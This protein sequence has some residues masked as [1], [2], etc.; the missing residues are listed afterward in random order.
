MFIIYIKMSNPTQA[1]NDK[2]AWGKYGEFKV[3][4]MLENGYI[5]ANSHFFIKK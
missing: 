1:I 3:L 4:I 5:N 2:Y